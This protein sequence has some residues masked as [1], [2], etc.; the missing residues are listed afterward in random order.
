MNAPSYRVAVAHVSPVFL[1]TQET[2]AKA[3]DLIAEAARAG[4]A[5]I[6]FPETFV[7]AFPIWSALQAP[8]YNHDFFTRLA[9][10][11]VRV[12]G[13][14]T[15]QVAETARRH[16][17]FVSLGIN[18]GTAASV[19]CIWNSNLLFGD[20][21]SIINHHRKLVPTFYEKMTWTPGDGAGL[22][23]RE[24]RLGRLGMLICG[25]NTNPL[26]RYTLIAQGEQLHISS[27][28]P[29]WPTRDPGD[30]GNYDLADSIR[31][32][33]AGHSFEA[34]CFTVVASAFLDSVTRNALKVCGPDAERI[35]DGSPNGVSMVVDPMGRVVDGMLQDEEGLLY[36]DVDLTACVEPKQF[37]DVAGGYNRFDVFQL[38]V[39][40][41][42]N[43][44]IHFTDQPAQSSAAEGPETLEADRHID[45]EPEAEENKRMLATE[46]GYSNNQLDNGLFSE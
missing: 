3:C 45:F 20:D 18:E 28:P 11:A 39:N 37:H 13:P 35:M 46:Q 36:A 9:H 41:R 2:I 26:A 4:A 38:A 25:E 31:I 44:P 32:R 16:G 43:R 14:E 23:V 5:L 27:Y 7:S 19:G 42:A 12:P 10:A 1:D 17:I 34:K 21:G 40:R 29:I 24:T 22:V 33:A 6:A 15:A 8:I 30:A